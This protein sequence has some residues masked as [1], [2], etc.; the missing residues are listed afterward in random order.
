MRPITI[1]AAMLFVIPMIIGSRALGQESSV[2][3]DVKSLKGIDAVQ[4]V[5]DLSD[6]G[7]VSDLDKYTIRTDVELKLRAAGMRSYLKRKTLRL[8]E[9][10]TSI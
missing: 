8:P 3:L 5:I 9:V 7:K 4:V 1:V 10:H 6:T 2:T